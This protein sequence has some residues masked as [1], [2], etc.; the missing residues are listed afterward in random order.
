MQMCVTRLNVSIETCH[1][2]LCLNKSS[3]FKIQTLKHA[4]YFEKSNFKK[5][6]RTYAT[7]EHEIVN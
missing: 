6:T 5:L 3:C 1:E 7:Q 4:I 2:L